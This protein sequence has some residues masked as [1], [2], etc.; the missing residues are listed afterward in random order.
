MT[1]MAENPGFSGTAFLALTDRNETA[2]SA[3]LT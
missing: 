1:V 2:A 3:V